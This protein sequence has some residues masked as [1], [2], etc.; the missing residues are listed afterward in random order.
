MEEVDESTGETEEVVVGEVA[1]W[2]FVGLFADHFFEFA[3]VVERNGEEFPDEE[4][5]E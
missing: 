3:G 4:E 5:V 1:F 2:N